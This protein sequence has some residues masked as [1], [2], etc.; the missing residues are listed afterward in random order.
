MPH[1]TTDSEQTFCRCRL[2]IPFIYVQL[3]YLQP[4]FAIIGEHL[5]HWVGSL[6]L[7]IQ[8]HSTDF[9]TIQIL[10]TTTSNFMKLC[11]LSQSVCVLC[12]S[13]NIDYIP[14]RHWPVGLYKAYWL[15]FCEVRTNVLYIIQINI[16][17]QRDNKAKCFVMHQF[18]TSPALLT[19]SGL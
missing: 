7:F 15:V 9:T 1:L 12:N 8:W 4:R 13:I 19:P 2:H 11:I 3:N 10:C 16:S 5:A 17:L 14:T 18:E 6:L